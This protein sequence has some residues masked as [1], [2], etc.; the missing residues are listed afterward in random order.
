MPAQGKSFLA[1]GLRAKS[2]STS[3]HAKGLWAVKAKNGGKWPAAKPKTVKASPNPT[4]VKTVKKGTRSVV[5]PRVP[6][7]F[8]NQRDGTK[9]GSYSNNA[10]RIRSSIVPGRVC[11]VLA[12]KFVGRRVIVLKSLQSGLVVV[13]GPSKLNTVPMRRVNPSYLIAT[14]LRIDLVKANAVPI[15]FENREAINDKLF[16]RERGR[17]LK[18]ARKEKNTKK[19]QPKEGEEGK[20]AKKVK[21][22]LKTPRTGVVSKKSQRARVTTDNKLKELS[23]KAKQ[24]RSIQKALDA[25]LLKEVRKTPL[26][27]DYLGGRFQLS[28]GQYPH[29]LKF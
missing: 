22:I 1:K 20:A 23:E 9:K 27:A 6:R 14:S 12:G 18:E 3:Y 11:I 8:V 7:T 25:A 13:T 29:E 24:R 17:K 2:S 5:K 21:V 26:L 4:V 28:N 19:E 15:L 10:P 16:E